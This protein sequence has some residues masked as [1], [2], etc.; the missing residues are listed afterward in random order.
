MKVHVWIHNCGI[1]N[2][3]HV[4]YVDFQLE[5]A[6]RIT[7]CENRDN[8]IVSTLGHLISPLRSLLIIIF[9]LVRTINH[10]NSAISIFLIE[11][12][13]NFSMIIFSYQRYSCLSFTILKR[14]W[15]VKSIN[16]NYIMLS[17][18]GYAIFQFT[19][20]YFDKESR[21]TQLT[22]SLFLFGIFSV[23]SMSLVI[24]FDIVWLIF[25]PAVPLIGAIKIPFALRQF[26]SQGNLGPS[27]LFIFIMPDCS[28]NI[29]R[30]L[31]DY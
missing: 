7:A 12:N 3:H 4:E 31:H 17:N 19:V 26:H 23:S 5:L 27:F 13:F 15:V 20:R 2:A 29:L 24:M 30:I 8:T 6:S 14:L 10:W 16:Y 25:A 1:Q 11:R 9:N 28:V 22:L 21:F 18:E